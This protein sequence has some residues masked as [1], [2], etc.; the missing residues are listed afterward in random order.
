MVRTIYVVFVEDKVANTSYLKMV[1][2]VRIFGV[3]NVLMA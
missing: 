3:A 2:G 1:V